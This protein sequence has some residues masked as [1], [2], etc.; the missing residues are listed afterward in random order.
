[1]R[2]IPIR[3]FDGFGRSV[4][5]ADVAHELVSDVSDRR[6]DSSCDHVAFDLGE[7]VFD[8]VEPRGVG[9]RIVQ[10]NAGMSG[11]E[12]LRRWDAGEYTGQ[13][14]D[15]PGIRQMAMLMPFAR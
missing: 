6:E 2:R 3:P 10:M 13:E 8:L 12:F 9:R 15:E 7:P 5:V 14:C 11:E 4:V 1:M